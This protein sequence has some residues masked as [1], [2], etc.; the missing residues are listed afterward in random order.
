MSLPYFLTGLAILE[1]VFEMRLQLMNHERA[2]VLR[3]ANANE[4]TELARLAG[5]VEGVASVRL[6]SKASRTAKY[7]GLG[8]RFLSKSSGAGSS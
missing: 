2:R 8:S 1:S 5:T 3:H 6:A 4:K 7:A